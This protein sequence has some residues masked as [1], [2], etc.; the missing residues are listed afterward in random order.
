MMAEHGSESGLTL[1]EVL[2][3]LGIVAMAIGL[4]LPMLQRG[5]SPLQASTAAREILAVLREARTV[6]ITENRVIAVWVDTKAG[7]FGYGERRFALPH[8]AG[9]APLSLMLYTTE[10]QR[11]GSSTGGTGMIRFF[12]AGGSTG[13]GVAVSDSRRH[14]LITVDWLSGQIRMTE[15]V[16]S[17]PDEHGAVHAAR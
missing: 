8:P 17:R 16:L 6:A 2:V 4:G 7:T 9:N 14:I 1:V 11:V 10:D 15:G 12:P 13:G 3:A 5:S